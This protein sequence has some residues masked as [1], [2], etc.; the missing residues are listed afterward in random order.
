[1]V[2][3]VR[4]SVY[5]I[6]TL[7]IYSNVMYKQYAGLMD[8]WT[9]NILDWTNSYNKPK[10]HNTQKVIFV[11]LTN[12]NILLYTYMCCRVMELQEH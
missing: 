3:G 9:D 5:P 11:V 7:S 2:I 8:W 6:V 1:M 4:L 12:C 10:D